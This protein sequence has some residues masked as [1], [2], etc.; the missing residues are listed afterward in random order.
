MTL[1]DYVENLAFRVS[2]PSSLQKTTLHPTLKKV[3]HD[4]KNK[5][6]S[7]SE[8][9]CSRLTSLKS[10]ALILLTISLTTKT[11]QLSV[12]I[13]ES[14]SHFGDVTLESLAASVPTAYGRDVM[15]LTAFQR[16]RQKAIDLF[17]RKKRI[18]NSWME[19]HEGQ[20]SKSSRFLHASPDHVFEV[21]SGYKIF[22]IIFTVVWMFFSILG[23]IGISTRVFLLILVT[24]VV[25]FIGICQECMLI[26]FMDN[27]SALDPETDDL[28]HLST[29]LNSMNQSSDDVLS[30]PSSMKFINSSQTSGDSV[31]KKVADMTSSS[32][33][34]EVNNDSQ[35]SSPTGLK[36]SMNTS[37]EADDS[38]SF[39]SFMA[40]YTPVV[41]DLITIMLLLFYC[42]WFMKNTEAVFSPGF[43][44]N[45]SILPQSS[46]YEAD[47]TA[48]KNTLELKE[49]SS[50]FVKPKQSSSKKVKSAIETD[51][52][53]IECRSR[54]PLPDDGRQDDRENMK[55]YYSNPLL[56]GKT[57]V[58]SFGV[59]YKEFDAV[60]L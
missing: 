54:T 36:D 10:L 35:V 21:D 50:S 26:V 13:Y 29:A 3:T 7:S 1:L 59:T 45:E 57:G 42:C 39:L 19:T 6:S 11:I 37:Q 48:A 23:I 34:N 17:E 25:Y 22:C 33:F 4:V 8:S 24:Q 46:F 38:S 56:C 15:D 9:C 20:K 31:H 30:T 51:D 47:V 44:N 40:C 53:D 2:H 41:V 27:P 32:S 52:D 60:D 12:I 55:R 28:L 58:K 43:S 49:V 16:H 14:Y 18:Y 5:M